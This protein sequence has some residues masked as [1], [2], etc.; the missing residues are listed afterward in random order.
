LLVTNPRAASVADVLTYNGAAGV[1]RS[2]GRL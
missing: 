2:L 1:A